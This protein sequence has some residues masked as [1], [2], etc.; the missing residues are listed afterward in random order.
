M[1][2]SCKVFTFVGYHP[3]G[4]KPRLLLLPSDDTSNTARQLLSALAIYN[5]FSSVDKASPF[6]VEPASRVGYRVVA[7][8]SVAFSVFVS[9]METVLSL[10]LATKSLVPFLFNSNSLG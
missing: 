3:T 10:E 2:L 4:I 6:V 9:M 7:I 8:V 1:I 5:L